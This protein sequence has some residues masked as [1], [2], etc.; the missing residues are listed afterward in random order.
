MGWHLTTDASLVGPWVAQ[1]IG[2]SYQPGSVAIGLVRDGGLTAGVL[3]EQ[4]NGRSIVAHIA[5]TGRMT[6]SFLAAI[7]DYPFRVCGAEKIMCPIPSNNERSK[8]LATNMGFSQEACLKDAAPSGD[9]L[10][11]TLSKPDCRFLK[12][13]YIGKIRTHA[14]SRA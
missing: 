13:R 14:P 2:G 9:I 12:D 5:V 11:F 1:Q 10:I 3:Y 6:P 8:A 7:F 4:W